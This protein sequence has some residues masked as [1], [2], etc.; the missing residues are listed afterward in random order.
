MIWL[1]I[2]CLLA[3]SFVF[4][5]I[6]A[7]ILSVNRVRLRHHVKNRDRAAIRLKRLLDH[8]ERLLVTVI[9]VTNLMNIAAIT[10]TAQTLV[11]HVGWRG[12][13]LTFALFLPLNL[14]L[15]EVL[16][17]SLFRRFPYR[18]LA[19]LA[20]PLRIADLLLTPLHFVG[21]RLSRLFFGK[22][23]A[24]QQKLFVGREDFKYFTV[25][26]ESIGALSPTE[27]AMIHNVIDFRA[28][29]ARELMIPLDRVKTVSP[30]ETVGELLA[31]SLPA[32][33]QRWPVLDETG[34]ITGVVD[35]F[36]LA[37]DV[38]REDAVEPHQRRIVRV[39]P[40]EPAYAALRKLRAARVALAVIEE[41]GTAVGIVTTEDLVRRLIAAAGKP[42]PVPAVG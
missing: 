33:R 36:E 34:K 15:L 21:W 3:V 1:A 29:T 2:V 16:P 10:L 25:E 24:E 7:G 13:L 17:K 37:L 31:R 23:P 18:A 9:I 41:A 20:E 19:L 40:N 35:T 11:Q 4:S 42:A 5:G 38:P 26:S 28:V 14:F 12:Y 22:R 27:R 6:E 30:R 32:G 39:A 8:P